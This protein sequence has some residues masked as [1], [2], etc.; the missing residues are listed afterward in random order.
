MG[1]G[2]GGN[3]GLITVKVHAMLE[4]KQMAVKTKVMYHECVLVD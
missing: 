1:E 3:V 2:E 4:S